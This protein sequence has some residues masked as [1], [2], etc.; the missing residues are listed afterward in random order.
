MG[1]LLTTVLLDS[2][3]VHWWTSEELRQLSRP[4]VRAIERADNL[5]V[6]SISWW[7]LAWLVRSERIRIH[8]PMRSWLDGLAS[9]FDTVPLTPAIAE[10]AASLSREFPSDPADRIIYATAIET[11]FQLVTKDERMRSYPQPRK[12]IIW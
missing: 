6:A 12:I 7:E 10:A 1:V 4:A 9:T 5:A 3:V 11:G 8:R 2:H